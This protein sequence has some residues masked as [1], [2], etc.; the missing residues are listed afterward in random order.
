MLIGVVHLEANA[1][2]PTHNH[3]HEQISYIL[4]GELEFDLAGEK[5]T[6][7]PGDIVVI[8]ENV[9]HTVTAGSVQSKVVDTFSPVREDL[10]Y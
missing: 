8:P 3:P 7:H 4:E 10:K 1:I 5:R 2:M 6:V 9:D